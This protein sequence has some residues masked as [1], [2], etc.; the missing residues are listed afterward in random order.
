[1]KTKKSNNEKQDCD[2]KCENERK[3][4]VDVFQKIKRLENKGGQIAL[5]FYKVLKELSRKMS[6]RLIFRGKGKSWF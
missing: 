1:L 4:I 5:L 3:E 2:C 6:F